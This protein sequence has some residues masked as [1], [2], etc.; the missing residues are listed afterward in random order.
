MIWL[1]LGV[2][3]WSAAHLFKRLAPEMRGGMGD[4]GKGV[5]ALLSL[6]AIVLM[7]LGYRAAEV[8][9]LWDL[10]SWTI[11]VNNLLM[12]GA[13]ALTGVGSSKSRLRGA[14]RH[15]MLTGFLVWVVAH[16]LVNGDL[17]SLILFGG[18]GLWAITAILMINRAEPAPEPF[19]DGTVQGDIRLAV[20]TIVVFAVIA[21]AHTWLGNWPFPG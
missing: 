12:L 10:G 15:P 18:L 13:V 8:A 9:P 7:V 21:A 14:M 4:A 11:S 20:I 2:F 1:I 5:V 16:L 6:T 17:S 3:L 19:N